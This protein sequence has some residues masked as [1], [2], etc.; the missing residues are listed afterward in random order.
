MW[1]EGMWKKE[2]AATLLARRR[3]ERRPKRTTKKSAS[4]IKTHF[5]RGAASLF[6][7]VRVT[8]YKLHMG[9]MQWQLSC[10]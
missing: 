9:H 10:A 8:S 6:I 3:E 2:V 1:D 5:R 4:R 7:R